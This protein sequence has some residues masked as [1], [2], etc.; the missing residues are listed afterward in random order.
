MPVPARRLPSGTILVDTPSSVPRGRAV[1]YARVSAH[2]QRADLDREVARVVLWAPGRGMVVGGV[3]CEVGAGMNGKRPKLARVL[4]DATVTTILV[5][6]RD[7]LARFSVEHLEAA[8]ATQGSRLVVTDPG[9]ATDDL[10]R[11]SIDLLTSS[12]ARLYGRRD[13]RNHTLRAVTC[14]ERFPDPNG[15]DG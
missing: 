1:V 6:H 11:D 9:E 10:L 14:V 12:C 2:D 7:R 13:A 15:Q 4:A 5:E 3:V 8:L